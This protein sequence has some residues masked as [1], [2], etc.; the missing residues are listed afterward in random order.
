M[1]ECLLVEDTQCGFKCFTREAAQATAEQVAGRQR[2]VM[3]QLH[4][5]AGA[6]EQIIEGV[7]EA[8]SGSGIHYWV[9]P[10]HTAGNI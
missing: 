1:D 9:T 6:A 2:Q 8:F 3:F 10:L 5:P 4:V 7:R